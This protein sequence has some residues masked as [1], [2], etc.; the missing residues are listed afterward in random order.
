MVESYYGFA[1]KPFSLTPDP[2]FFYLSQDHIDAL[3]HLVYGIGEG[4]GF[5]LLCGPVGTGKT[6]LS[7][8]LG[9]RLGSRVITS[10]I[11]NPFQSWIE[12]LKNILWDFGIIPEGTVASELAG[13]LIEFLIRE[14]GPSG[15][16]ALIMI[17]EAQNLSAETLEQLRVLSN[18]ETEK[19]KLLQI[20][21]LGQEELLV[22]LARPELR[23]LRQ[24]ISIKYLLSPLKKTEVASYLAHRLAVARPQRMPV[25]TPGATRAIYRFSGGIPRLINMVAS[26]SLVGGFVHETCEIDRRIVKKALLSLFGDKK[27]AIQQIERYEDLPDDEF[28][29][30]PAPPPAEDN[31][32]GPP[33]KEA[34]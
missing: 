11:L 18:V 15:R 14:I 33:C 2:R 5:L 1:E 12:L 26:R 7:R 17:D 21:L 9:E 4:E 6:T 10:L 8:V 30:P 20:L 31:L 16:T 19:E 3:E 29:R 27:R 28:P 23:Q 24:R 13:Q 25:F 34:P 22:K 32:A